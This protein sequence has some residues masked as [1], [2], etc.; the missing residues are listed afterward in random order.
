M[1]PYL[2]I[3]WCQATM[4]IS[5]DANIVL[6]YLCIPRFLLWDTLPMG[7]SSSHYKNEKADLRLRAKGHWKQTN[8]NVQELLNLYLSLTQ[9][10]VG[11]GR[12]QQITCHLLTLVEQ[13]RDSLESPFSLICISLLWGSK[14]ECQDTT[15]AGMGRTC[16]LLKGLVGDWTQVWGSSASHCTIVPSPSFRYKI[17]KVFFPT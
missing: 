5:T 4:H 13:P 9:G 3:G 17:K 8:K 10:A 2:P 7:G 1:L 11:A 6:M 15:L 16:K 14:P 12:H